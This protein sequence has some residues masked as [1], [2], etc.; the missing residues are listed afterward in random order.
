MSSKTNLGLIIAAALLVWCAPLGGMEADGSADG[1][2]GIHPI[3]DAIVRACPDAEAGRGVSAR[4]ACA[5]RLGKMAQLAN[6]IESQ[7]LLWGGTINS[8]FNPSTDKLTRLDPFVWRKLYLSLFSFSGYRVE[9]LA[10][11]DKLLRLDAKIR[12][13]APEEYPYPFWHSAAKWQEYQQSRQVALLFRNNVMI[14]GYR[15]AQLDPTIPF[16]PKAW[17]G[18]WTWDVNGQEGP[19]VSLYNYTL[20][21]DNPNRAALE[22]AY[23]DFEAATRPYF[24]T[25]CHNPGNPANVNPL[26]FFTHPSQALVARHDIVRRLQA[27][28][29]PPNTGIADEKARQNLIV[30][31]QR[32]AELGDKAL[33]YESSQLTI[34]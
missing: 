19:R 14:A 28:T 34:K 33:A 6:V 13:I 29:M 18:K 9:T 25:G 2:A 31:A 22:A 12:P 24:C 30:L 5:D 32:F 15:N 21:R 23:R 16:T 27:N 8:T 26:V 4:D 11:G 20:S 7:G 17:D 1:D 3:G 10:N